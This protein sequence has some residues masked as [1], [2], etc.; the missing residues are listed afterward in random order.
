MKIATLNIDWSKRVKQQEIEN[1]LQQYDFDFLVLTEAIHLNLPIYNYKYLS[2]QIPENQV[3]E[4]LNYTEYLN[5]EKA[6]RTIIYSKTSAINSFEVIDNKTSL[7]LEFQTAFGNLVIYSTIIGTWFRKKP[8]AEKELQNCINDCEKIYQTNQNL[9]IV[10]DLNTSFQESE[11][12]F[13]INQKTTKSLKLLFEKHNLM[14]VTEQIE[15]NIDHIIIPRFFKDKLVESKSFV[16]KNILSD[17][18]GIF[19]NLQNR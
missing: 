19:I 2:E 8:F 13:S 14:N 12:E 10:G 4:G 3:Y 9:I 1:Y 17:H 11:K 6:F 18:K 15:K 5:G 7:A 16:E